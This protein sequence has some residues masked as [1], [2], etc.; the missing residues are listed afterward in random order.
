MLM[1]LARDFSGIEKFCAHTLVGDPASSGVLRKNG[2]V[3]VGTVV[4][5]VDGEVARFERVPV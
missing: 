4:D 2:F 5:P 3:M 1:Q